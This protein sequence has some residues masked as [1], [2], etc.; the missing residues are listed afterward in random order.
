MLFAY[1]RYVLKGGHVVVEEGQV[2]AITEGREFICRPKFDEHIEDYIRPQF[3]KL[4]TMSFEN[5]P[6]DLERMHQHDIVECEPQ[7]GTVRPL[8]PLPEPAPAPGHK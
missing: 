3:S 1:P 8:P 5:Y 7:P 2:R 4:Y 6:T